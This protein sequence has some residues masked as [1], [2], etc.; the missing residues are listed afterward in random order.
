MNV[1]DIS[2]NLS[3]IY[4]ILRFIDPYFL[5]GV[6]FWYVMF[7]KSGVY[8]LFISNIIGIL[9]ATIIFVLLGLHNKKSNHNCKLRIVIKNEQG[10]KIINSFINEP[11]LF[12]NIIVRIASQ[13][14]TSCLNKRIAGT[15]YPSMFLPIYIVIFTLFFSN[16]ILVDT[17]NIPISQYSEILKVSFVLSSVYVIGFIIATLYMY[18][19]FYGIMLVLSRLFVTYGQPSVYK[20]YFNFNGH[21]IIDCSDKNIDYTFIEYVMNNDYALLLVYDSI[22]KKYHIYYNNY[23]AISHKF[24]LKRY[25]S[26]RKVRIT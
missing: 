22:E 6:S 18:P 20:K 17:L 13:L 26:I 12:I 3:Q 21:K 8:R 23:D 24:V 5:L 25:V 11:N 2:N 7:F 16:Y 9:G 19:S 4:N 1:L 10:K 15:T 14:K